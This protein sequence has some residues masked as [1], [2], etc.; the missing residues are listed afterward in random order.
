MQRRQ[1]EPEI[2]ALMTVRFPWIE[3]ERGEPSAVLSH[4]AFAALRRGLARAA[5]SS[6]ETTARDILGFVEELIS[7]PLALHPDVEDAIAVSFI[8]DLYLS[9]PHQRGFAEPLLGPAT[10]NRWNE[11]RAAYEGS[12]G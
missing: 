12:S 3:K 11:I 1:L 9:A 4:L 10:R 7:Q 8:E 5:E 2:W 6:D